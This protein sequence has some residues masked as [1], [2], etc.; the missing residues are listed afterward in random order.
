MIDTCHARRP[1]RR[2]TAPRKRA[3]MGPTDVKL[4]D[5]TSAAWT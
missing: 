5:L 3:N 4:Y 2:R 1:L